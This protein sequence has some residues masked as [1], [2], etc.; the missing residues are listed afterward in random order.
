MNNELKPCP[1]CGHKAVLQ[2]NG[3]RA[4]GPNALDFCGDYNTSWTAKC[5]Y[6][7]TNK[8]PFRTDYIFSFD[9]ELIMHGKHDGRGE[10]IDAWNRRTTDE[11]RAD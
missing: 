1:F 8:G 2:H 3:L 4:K 10:A 7:G 5:T 6:C 9:G 11:N